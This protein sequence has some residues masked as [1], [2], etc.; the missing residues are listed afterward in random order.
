M[1]GRI[2][3]VQTVSKF[4]SLASQTNVHERKI[5]LMHVSRN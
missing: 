3:N 1:M 2:I 5:F 4:I